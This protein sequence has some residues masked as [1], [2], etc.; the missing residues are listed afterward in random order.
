MT[1]LVPIFYFLLLA[2]YKTSHRTQFLWYCYK[3]YSCSYPESKYLLQWMWVRQI[4]VSPAQ[5]VFS[6]YDACTYAQ[7]KCSTLRTL[8]H[9]NGMR[10]WIKALIHVQP[11]VRVFSLQYILPYFSHYFKQTQAQ[12]L[13]T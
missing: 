7:I 11:R 13:A 3:I 4:H 2:S 1:K 12:K 9:R 6:S 10:V 5:R 8:K